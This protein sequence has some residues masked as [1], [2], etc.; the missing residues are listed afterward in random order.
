M[1]TLMKYGITIAFWRI[2]TDCPWL[3]IGVIPF[4]TN[5]RVK[6]S[7][8]IRWIIMV[9]TFYIFFSFF[10]MPFN[11]GFNPRTLVD[12]VVKYAYYFV[13]IVF[14]IRGFKVFWGQLLYMFLFL[15]STSTLFNNT[16]LI[17]NRLI[18]GDGVTITFVATPSYPLIITL[19]NLLAFPF[20][21]N[22]FRK[23][24][25]S[26]LS[27]LSK[28]NILNLCILPVIF[29]IINMFQYS[30][31]IE[32]LSSYLVLLVVQIS[33]F[34][35]YFIN[36][37]LV[38]ESVRRVRL[39]TEN[40]SL[41]QM[42]ALQQRGYSQLTENIERARADRHDMRFHL[43]VLLGFL[44]EEKYEKSKEYL[45]MYSQGLTEAAIAPLCEHHTIDVLARHFVN[46]IEASGADIDVRL[47]VPAATGISDAD[48]CVVFGNLLENASNS[49]ANQNGGV[50]RA[51][52]ETDNGSMV[53][54][55]GNSCGATEDAAVTYGIG[56]N[57]VAA[58][59]AKY[60]GSARFEREEGMFKVSVILYTIKKDGV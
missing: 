50:F 54:A 51:Y 24:L 42:I 43:S 32:T 45:N 55:I 37:S 23:T 19:F 35:S 58:V 11:F 31:V 12:I 41:G 44:Q 33:G 30:G 46:Q 27:E 48:L 38:R 7:T 8:M 56:L 57:S 5:L 40:R 4:W 16:S 34:A 18:L 10:V 3:V 9:N 39:E 28:R 60:N 52:C 29:L 49:L 6:K 14:Y 13:I 2:F 1:S 20:L 21:I 26:T 25:R 53:I 15:Y 22:F 36:L 17:I 59:A 47:S